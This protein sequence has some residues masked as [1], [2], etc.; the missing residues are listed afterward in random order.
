[1]EPHALLART[2]HADAWE[3]HGLL[4]TGRGG[5]TGAAPGVR[6]MASGLP[7][8]QWNNGDVTDPAL[9]DVA[10]LRAWYEPLAVPWGVRVPAGSAWPHGTFLFR[11]HLVLRDAGPV[12]A[13]AVPGLQVRVAGP[14]DLST[15]VAVDAAAFDG[16]P[17]LESAWIEPHLHAPG[18]VTV[19]LASLDGA[20]VAT[21][22]VLRSDGHAGPAAYL[23]GLAA[24]P[25]L[26]DV[27]D[28]A[29]LAAV[30]AW[31][32]RGAFT[33]GARVALAHPDTE[34]ETVTLA[35]LGLAPAG[36]LDVYV[37]LA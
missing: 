27:P 6:L 23:S 35:G 5:A 9:V 21:G 28:R 1:M 31:L 32:L 25:D 29:V 34:E 24:V 20:P 30:G 22:Y 26:P 36:A 33:A 37:D 4:R 12:D 10:A 16:D 13:P 19:A 3:Q 18:P 2:V 17:A 15:V 11:K 7:H 14:N 8:P